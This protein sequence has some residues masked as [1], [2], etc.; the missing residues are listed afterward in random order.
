VPQCCGVGTR[1]SRHGSLGQETVAQVVARLY[2]IGVRPD[3]WK[4][5]PQPDAAAW[6]AIVNV[7]RACDAVCRGV[8]L[9]GLDT[10]TEELMGG[11]AD[12]VREPLVRGF[13]VG[14]IIFGAA[15]EAWLAGR[16]DHGATVAECFAA[17]VSAWQRA[18]R[19]P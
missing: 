18:G 13:A 6:Q 7:V 11:F 19:R 17:I 8:P 10:P 2:D 5:E 12:A 3:W 1:A 4:L 16:V 15:A 14:R 9:L